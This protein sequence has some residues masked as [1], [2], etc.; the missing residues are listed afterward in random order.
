MPCADRIADLEVRV[1]ALLERVVQLTAEV[2]RLKP[3]EARVARLE[4]ENATL[5]EKLARSSR[6]SSKPPSS[7][8]PKEKAER[9]TKKPTGRAAHHFRKLE[10]G[11]GL[12]RDEAVPGTLRR[13][14]KGVASS[15]VAARHPV[16]R[17]IYRTSQGYAARS[18]AGGSAPPPAFLVAL[19]A[20]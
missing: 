5:R 13:G 20:R 8:S 18:H 10:G 19:D 14:R 6:N 9:P 1:A 4:V 7:D 2:E 17:R 3:F 15:A 12:R 16:E 11:A